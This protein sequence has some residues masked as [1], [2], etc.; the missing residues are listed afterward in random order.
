MLRLP[1]AI[2]AA[3]IASQMFIA[4]ASDKE[5]TTAGA[6]GP[7]CGIQCGT[8]CAAR[9]GGACVCTLPGPSAATALSAT[10]ADDLRAAMIDER[11]AQ[12]FYA[13][14]IAKYGDVRPFSNVVHAEERHEAL[15]R[16]LLERYDLAAPSGPPPNVPA[17]PSTL[18]ECNRLAAQLERDNVAMYDR[19]LANTTEP[20]V[21]AAFERLRAVSLNNHLP[22]FERWSRG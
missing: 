6:F 14:V 1:F 13:A 17:V 12:A 21:R 22:A 20:D 3:A 19:M 11:R 10:T 5:T 18:T 8:Q 7:P 16:T 15:V 2:V 9:C 4:C